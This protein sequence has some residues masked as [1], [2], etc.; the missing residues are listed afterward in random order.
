MKKA[1]EFIPVNQP[2]IG[3]KEKEYVL[4]ALNT[5]WISSEGPF[6]T[7]FEKEFSNKVNRKFI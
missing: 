7:K 3:E 5:G 2:V 4:E 6:V 1:K